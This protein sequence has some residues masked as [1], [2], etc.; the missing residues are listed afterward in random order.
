MSLRSS[1]QSKVAKRIVLLFVLC[2]LVPVICLAVV[3]S[4]QVTRE[5]RQATRQRL[6]QTAKSFGIEILDQL[7][8]L[9]SDLMLVDETMVAGSIASPMDSPTLRHRLADRFTAIAV[10]APNGATRTLLGSNP[11]VTAPSAAET[12]HLGEGKTVVRVLT[13]EQSTPRLLMMRRVAPSESTLLL[14][15]E[16]N[17]SFL[18]NA[19]SVP[20]ET[21]VYILGPSLTPMFVSPSAPPLRLDDA[22]RRAVAA[23]ATGEAEWSVDGETYAAQYWT[24]PIDFEFV[25]PELKI[26]ASE[27]R[28]DMLAPIRSSRLTFILVM[29]LSLWVVTFFALSQVRRSMVPLARLREGTQRL[30][31]GDFDGRVEIRSGDEFE[32][33]AGSFNTMAG[34]LKRQFETLSAMAELDRSVLSSLDVE[35]IVRGTLDRLPR[36][37]GCDFMA[38]IVLGPTSND[39][40]RAFVSHS[41]DRS[42]PHEIACTVA[43]RTRATLAQWNILSITFE[44]GVPDYLAAIVTPDWTAGVVFPLVFRERLVGI[45]VIGD[46]QLTERSTEDLQ[47]A[48][49]LATQVGVALSNADLMQALDRLNVG[50]LSALAR[51]VDAKSP[52]TAGHSQR[53]TQMAVDIGRTMGL[54]A[55]TLDDLARGGLLHDIGKIAVPTSV[56]NKE[57]PLT[58]EEFAVMKE[59]PR[60][61]ARILEP[62]PEYGHLI[63]IVL[64]HHEWFNGK[65]YPFGLAGE[66]IDLSA[67]V[68]AVADVYDALTSKRPYREALSHERAISII[69]DH[70]GTQFDPQVVD[71][72]FM[73]LA[74]TGIGRRTEPQAAASVVRSSVGTRLMI[75]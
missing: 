70:N 50:T 41:R 1:G 42:M 26:V 48:K 59:H 75:D 43:P 68:L 16:I 19:E 71:A 65:G 53:V 31:R 30:G 46:R 60:T 47:H 22:V 5:L 4:M 15:A 6:H 7:R 27:S 66:A 44:N 8:R 29:V 35:T 58:P 17:S 63:P 20:P 67:R 24:L 13:G 38:V 34:Q 57:G 54:S 21:D 28:S 45:L 11:V 3:A 37:I 39:H 49:Q 10:I 33:L 61:G 55:K 25:A 64:Q 12:S 2:A 52:W 40:A 62:I 73:M 51:T 14:S 72:F 23:S 69:A 9:E 36:L 74:A 18:M 32:E 56:L